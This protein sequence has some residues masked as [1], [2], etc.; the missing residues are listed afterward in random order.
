MDIIEALINGKADVSLKGYASDLT[1]LMIA[2]YK[3]YSKAVK[4]LLDAGADRTL[5]NDRDGGRLAIDYAKEQDYETLEDVNFSFLNRINVYMKKLRD[6]FFSIL[7][8]VF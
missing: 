2:Y 3:G 8:N 5:K 6:N 1:P 4:K 7:R